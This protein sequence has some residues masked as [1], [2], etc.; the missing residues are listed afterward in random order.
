MAIT[1]S[2]TQKSRCSGAG[3]YSIRPPPTIVASARPAAVAAVVM[4][5]AR[6]ALPV[7]AELDH[8][9]RRGSQCEAD[10]RSHQRTPGVHPADRRRDGEE[11][12]AGEQAAD[13]VQH[14]G[15]AADVVGQLSEE[16]QEDDQHDRVDGEDRGGRGRSEMPGRRVQ[17]VRR[18]RGR[19]G[20]QADARDRRGSPEAG[21]TTQGATW[22]RGGCG[23]RFEG[24]HG[25]LPESPLSCTMK[26]RTPES[27]DAIQ[28]SGV[29]PVTPESD[30]ARATALYQLPRA[31]G[32]GYG[33]QLRHGQS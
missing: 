1:A 20:P 32:S 7:R 5:E 31:S 28:I 2:S 21:P 11:E 26:L 9:G 27:P 22:L 23:G 4:D 24:G 12:D 29:I 15:A 25:F 13:A 8:R 19:A 10:T 6:A 33:P 30:P 18:R 3:A 17:R 16:Q 14:R